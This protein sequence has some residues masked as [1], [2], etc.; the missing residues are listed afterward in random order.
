MPVIVTV[1]DVRQELY[2]ANQGRA[3]AG[4]GAPST[5]LLGTWF[6]EGLGFLIGANEASSPLR[7]LAD[8]EQDLEVWKK[9]LVDLAYERFVG[10]KL[11]AAQAGLQTSGIRVRTFWHAMQQACHWLAGLSWELKPERA[12]R[13]S[14]QP[15]PWESLA[16]LMTTEEP[17]SC[18]FRE[19]GWSDSVQLVGIADAV[20]RL[21]KTGAWCAVEF[22]LGQTNPV[23]DLGQ[24]C[25]YHL[26]LSTS[27]VSQTDHS[28]ESLAL[29]SFTPEKREELFPA[30]KLMH[31]R[32]ALIELLGTLAG[33]NRGPKSVSAEPVDATSPAQAKSTPTSTMQPPSAEHLELGERMVKAFKEYNVRVTLGQP[34]IAGPAFLRFPIVLGKGTKVAS[35]QK[36]MSELQVRLQLLEAPFARVEAGQL[37]IEVQRPDRQLIPFEQVRA[38]IQAAARDHGR[39]RIPVGVDLTGQ[40]H[41]A[42]LSRPEHAHLLVV[43][44]TGSG[45]SEWLRFALA[46][47]VM[48][49][50][51]ET[52]RLVLIDPKRNAF[53]A[54]RSSPFLLR[55][56]VFPDEQDTA[57]L[58]S[59][60]ADEMD[61]RYRRFEGANTFL[62]VVERT[63]EVM[64]RIV[65]VCEEY[66]D[67]ITRSPVERKEIEQQVTRLGSK[68]RAAGIHLMISTQEASRETIKGALDTNMSAR[69]GLKMG[70]AIESRLLFGKN[71]AECLL[72]H[73]DLL[74]KDIGEPRRLQAPLLSQENLQEIFATSPS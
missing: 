45:K 65:C 46:G 70:K 63:G 10:P 60:L 21:K 58:L 17:I 67:L 50:T 56:L 42:D 64:P 61:R 2:R 7:G 23:A 69:V 52:L 31:A 11:T 19:P 5:A 37:G 24:A 28:G 38:Q 48:S 18:V 30:S 6:H 36:C 26:L 74:F 51:P 9:W 39:S 20:L 55:P 32:T 13:R 34:I 72:G 3:E 59:D 49:N 33:V 66:R 4:T 44:T 8:L 43:G 71:G 68:A 62:E 25:L 73:G 47:L 29:V 15:A 14:E 16:D 53:H 35:V 54:L 12:S 27:V 57:E 22:K 40:L 41:Y 1:S